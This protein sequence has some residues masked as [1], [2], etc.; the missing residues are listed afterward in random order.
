MRRSVVA[1]AR[2][3]TSS[4]RLFAEPVKRPNPINAG[5]VKQNYPKAPMREETESWTRYVETLRMAHPGLLAKIKLAKE[6]GK[7]LSFA[8]V[9]PKSLS[10]GLEGGIIARLLAT[11][12]I[13][14]I[15]T[16]MYAPSNDFVDEYMAA[17]SE[18]SGNG[19]FKPFLNF[20][21]SDLRPNGIRDYP[22]HLM[23]MLFTGTNAR[24]RIVEVIG[25][26]VNVGSHLASGA[27]TIRGSY[28]D[29]HYDPITGEMFDFQPGLVGAHSD[30]GNDRYLR[31]FSKYACDDGGILRVPDPNGDFSDAMVIIKPDSLMYPSARP[32]HIMDLFSSTGL[33]LIGTSL[34]SMSVV[35]ARDFYGFL[36]PIFERK[37]SHD[38]ESVVRARLENAFD[39]EVPSQVYT[40]TTALL[41][42]QHAQNEVGRIITF[43]TG[44]EPPYRQPHTALPMAEQL[45][46][47]PAKCLALLYR[48]KDAIATVRS[49]LGNTDPEKASPGTVRFDY[50]DDV[51]R[52]G[53]HAS[54][55]PE[56]LAR[57]MKI[58]KFGQGKG[59]TV[60]KL[61]DMW[62]V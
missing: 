55:S 36:E 44:V 34:F 32:G 27:K 13:N 35:Q 52:N 20:L 62:D 11:P 28:G 41:M 22:N 45:K 60:K 43:M 37:L 29:A 30:E 50:G 1:V 5:V 23:L 47:G 38:V 8:W 21:D 9:T 24:Q 33:Q 18:T 4:P 10:R 53:A 40:V 61:I 58:I 51:M 16:R 19:G 48:G 39:F 15:G 6:E 46:R 25:S 31:V 59:T 17:H 42:R 7:Q 57:E 2:F 26:Q 56:A 14:L 49:K 54:D 3:H 12:D